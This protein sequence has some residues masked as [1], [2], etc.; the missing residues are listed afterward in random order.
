VEAPLLALWRTRS[1]VA[2]SPGARISCAHLR[3]GMFHAFE[4][5]VAVTAWAAAASSTVA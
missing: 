1:Q 5:E 4:A 2:L 3:P